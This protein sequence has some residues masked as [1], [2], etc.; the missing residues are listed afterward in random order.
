[1][2]HQM[3]AKKHRLVNHL[4]AVGNANLPTIAL[5]EFLSANGRGVVR[6]HSDGRLFDAAPIGVVEPGKARQS[7]GVVQSVNGGTRRIRAAY[8]LPQPF[9]GFS[10]LESVEK[11]FSHLSSA[12]SAESDAEESTG[13]AAAW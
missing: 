9:F 4:E 6:N 3:A 1:M 8:N 10:C 11:S 12:P 13:S 2:L 7:N 5:I